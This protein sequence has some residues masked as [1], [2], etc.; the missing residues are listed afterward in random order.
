MRQFSIFFPAVLPFT[1]SIAFAQAIAATNS[2]ASAPPVPQPQLSPPLNNNLVLTSLDD[3]NTVAK[4]D[5]IP[6]DA[7]NT[8][9]D[10]FDAIK[11]NYVEVVDNRSL[12][13]SAIR[14]MLTRLDPHSSYMNN[15]E[16]QAFLQESEGQYA[17]IGVVLDIKAGSIRIV[18]AIEGSPAAKAGIQSGDIITQ[19]N[20]QNVSDLNL[21]ETTKLLDGEVGTTVNL[22]IMRNEALQQLTLTRDIIQTNSV[23]SKMLAPDY[24]YLRITQFQDDTADALTKEIESLR[25]KYQIKG[26][27]L[28]LR[29]N[30]GGILEAAI[31][32]TDLFLDEGEI[33]SIRGR[34]EQ[35]IDSYEAEKGDILNGAPIV[36]MVNSGTASAAEILAGA[37]QDK[38]R[39]LIVGQTTF[40]KGSV[41]T[42][43]PLFHGGAIK[44]TT[45]RYYTPSGNSIQATGITPQVQLSPLNVDKIKQIPQATEASLP[46]HLPNPTANKTPPTVVNNAL[47]NNPDESSLAEQDFPLYEALN[48]LT[49]IAI[50]NPTEKS[51]EAKPNEPNKA[52]PNEANR[53]VVPTP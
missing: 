39:A 33:V 20:G 38:K 10:V 13:E 19:V 9:V 23:S 31:E 34:N 1:M 49:A 12:M 43:S 24:A 7:L 42:V 8:F 35:I 44:L 37:L 32:T 18:S 21:S 2:N 41:Q 47:T 46:N 50:L 36:V 17:G 11:R 28:D 3:D 25:V 22:T 40:G 6:F 51:T 16:Y 29:D 4:P 14:G 30:P 53:P 27:V 52:P 26:V 45:A 15:E 5:D 48:I